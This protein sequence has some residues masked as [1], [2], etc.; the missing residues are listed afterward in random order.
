MPKADCT[1]IWIYGMGVPAF[2]KQYHDYGIEA[3]LCMLGGSGMVPDFV[4][5]DIGEDAI[6]MIGWDYCN[7][8]WDNA[9]SLA[10][11]EAY[12]ERW[13]GEYPTFDSAGSYQSTMLFLEAVKAANGDTTP[14]VVIPAL[15][16]LA[17]SGPAG[18]TSFTA[19]QDC[20]YNSDINML[21]E[22]VAQLPDRIGWKLNGDAI[23]HVSGEPPV[24]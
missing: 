23:P 6:G 21:I 4:L 13:D 8:E 17:Y 3:T 15:A 14:S 19:Y 12:L 2:M 18:S 1:L 9:E 5:T 20:Y 10:F 7:P 24:D 11:T 16:A 22:E